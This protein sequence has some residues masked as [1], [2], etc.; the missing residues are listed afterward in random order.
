MKQGSGR[1]KHEFPK[2]ETESIYADEYFI[3]TMFWKCK[4]VKCK[5]SD[6]LSSDTCTE[7]K[8]NEQ[9]H[10]PTLEKC[11]PIDTLYKQP[12]ETFDF[13]KM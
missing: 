8:V 12:A 2:V 5:F 3:T 1:A 4:V 10:N 13:A 7:T 9:I 11:I 6:A